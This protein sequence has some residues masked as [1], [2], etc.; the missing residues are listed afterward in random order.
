M[1]DDIKPPGNTSHIAL[2]TL[3]RWRSLSGYLRWRCED[4]PAAGRPGGSGDLNL[5]FQTTLSLL[6][7]ANSAQ[8]IV[9][10]FLGWVSSL[11]RV[12]SG[13]RQTFILGFLLLFVGFGEGG[14]W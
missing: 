2:S 8:V 5:Y 3:K 13:A 4:A 14:R 1:A 7:E 12:P 9:Y 10:W 6:R 11:S